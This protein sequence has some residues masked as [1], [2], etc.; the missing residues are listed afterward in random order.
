MDRA[1]DGQNSTDTG[2]YVIM[3][4]HSMIV[5]TQMMIIEGA[6]LTTM[7][8]C[9]GPCLTLFTSGII[10]TWYLDLYGMCGDVS[11]FNYLLYIQHIQQY[12]TLHNECFN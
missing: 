7:A 9:A 3:C 8:L 4:N 6:S 10:H 12:T 1:Q 2:S 11:I 5:T